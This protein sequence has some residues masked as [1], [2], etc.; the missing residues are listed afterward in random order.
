M[1]PESL[2]IPNDLTHKSLSTGMITFGGDDSI[3][4]G[5]ISELKSGIQRAAMSGFRS[6]FTFGQGRTCAFLPSGRAL[7]SFAGSQDSIS[8]S[9]AR[10]VSRLSLNTGRDPNGYKK[11]KQRKGFGSRVLDLDLALG[12]GSDGVCSG[13][14]KTLS[15]PAR[16]H[17]LDLNADKSVVLEELHDRCSVELHHQVLYAV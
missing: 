13:D 5:M 3:S 15:C 6:V 14:I 8:E 2:R 16:H 11:K 4:R 1:T 9:L 12:Y 10:Y 17:Q 7:S